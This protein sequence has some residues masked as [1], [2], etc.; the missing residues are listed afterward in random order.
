MQIYHFNNPHHKYKEVHDETGGRLKELDFRYYDCFCGHPG[1]RIISSTTRHHNHF[2]VVQ[3]TQCGTLRMNPYMT[4]GAIET[5]YKEI[6]GPVKRKNMT[7]DA[8]FARQLQSADHLFGVVSPLVAKDAMILDYGAG[9]GG[10]GMRFLENGYTGAH[11]FDYDA[12]YMAHG[13]AKGFGAHQP[14]NRYDIVTLSHVLEHI[15]DPVGFLKYAARD[16]LKTEGMVYIEVPMFD[17]H[18]KLIADFH[19]AHKFYFTH[20]SLSILARL[21]GF[22]TVY[23]EED[24]LVVKRAT[25]A[26]VSDADYAKALS[27]SNALLKKAK[28]RAK[29]TVCRQ[30]IKWL[31]GKKCDV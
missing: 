19:L 22:E 18:E 16:L 20:A 12:K 27:D 10:R 24:V 17:T 26:A 30:K 6:Y 23:E 13:V 11:I 2:D 9:A 15:N 3:C 7:A 5:Y 21:A 31:L 1:Y 14:G 25:V 8:L 4:D 29:K 28:A